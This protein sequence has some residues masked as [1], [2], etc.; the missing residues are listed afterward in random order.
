MLLSDS[1]SLPP[2]CRNGVCRPLLVSHCVPFSLRVVLLLVC[3]SFKVC[4]FSV[5]LIGV[6]CPQSHICNS[7]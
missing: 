4:G 1:P 3:L 6:Q 5:N 7:F 2:A